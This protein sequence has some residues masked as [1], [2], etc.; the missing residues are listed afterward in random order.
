MHGTYL[1]V[2][3]GKIGLKIQALRKGAKISQ[4]DL[5]GRAKV[6]RRAVQQLELG[7]GN[8]TI[9]T[10]DSLA[11]ALGAPLADLLGEPTRVESFASS[12]A[13]AVAHSVGFLAKFAALKPLRQRLALA[14]V[15]DDKGY[16]D[17]TVLADAPE[18]LRL[19][20]RALQK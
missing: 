9:Q 12:M 17:E 4:E 14:V 8:P 16:V 3:I 20:K 19:P 7:K 1:F 6:A 2:D 11:K 10:L 15:Y 13:N 18:W 5:A